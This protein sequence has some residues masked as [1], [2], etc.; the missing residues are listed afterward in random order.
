MILLMNTPITAGSLFFYIAEEKENGLMHG[1][2]VSADS[3]LWLVVS[4]LTHH[5]T[6]T[7]FPA[8]L[9]PLEKIPHR[10]EDQKLEALNALPKALFE[11]P[12][13]PALKLEFGAVDAQLPADMQGPNTIQ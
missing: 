4:S 12:I 3:Q 10:Y 2:V 9:V 5:A 7:Q 13:S 1:Q 8:Q 6:G 11:H